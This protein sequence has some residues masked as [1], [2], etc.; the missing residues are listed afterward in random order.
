MWLQLTICCKTYKKLSLHK[1]KS[2][3]VIY[4]FSCINNDDFDE[5]DKTA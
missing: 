2:L 1:L 5:N 4:L 3:T